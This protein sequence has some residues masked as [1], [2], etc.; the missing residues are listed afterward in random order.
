MGSRDI[1]CR[2]PETP[3]LLHQGIDLLNGGVLLSSEGQVH[4]GDIRG[5]H[6]WEDGRSGG[7]PMHSREVSL[8]KL[9]EN[10]YNIVNGINDPV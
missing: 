6:T 3:S 7:E 10:A 5:G 1:P 8:L 9:R 4:H 2:Q